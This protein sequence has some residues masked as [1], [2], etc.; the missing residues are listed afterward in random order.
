MFFSVQNVE[1]NTK[2]QKYQLGTI[3][4][5]ERPRIQNI[6]PGIFHTHVASYVENCYSPNAVTNV[7]CFVIL[8]HVLHV[9]K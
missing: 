7:H 5:V 1:R 8:V 6:K 4:S 3:V 9:Q 2:N